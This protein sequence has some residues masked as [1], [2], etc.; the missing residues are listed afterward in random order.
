MIVS[1]AALAIPFV[2]AVSRASPKRWFRAL[3]ALTVPALATA[4]WYAPL[5]VFL[6]WIVAAEVSGSAG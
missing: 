6:A 3:G 5:A 1:G 2:I 4:Y